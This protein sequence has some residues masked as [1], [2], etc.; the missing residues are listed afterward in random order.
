MNRMTEDQIERAVERKIDRLDARF[1][2]AQL[3]Q[4][5]YDAEMKS[6]SNW[7]TAQYH[8]CRT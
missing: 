8:F 5:E 6:I 2:S 1:T 3:T 7:A 4:Q